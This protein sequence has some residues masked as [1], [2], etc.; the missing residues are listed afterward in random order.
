MA[1][2]IK[3]IGDVS[4]TQRLSRIKDQDLQLISPTPKYKTFGDK[5][6]YIQYTVYDNQRTLLYSSN[7]YL[8]YKLPSNSTLTPEGNYPIIE[9]NPVKDLEDVGYISGEFITQYN[10][11]K[12]IISGPTP[13]LFI[14]EISEDR[15]EIR[16]NSTILSSSQLISW[17]R[18][19]GSSI[20]NNNEQISYILNFPDNLQFLIINFAV[21]FETATP[22]LLLKLYEPLALNIVEKTLGWISEEIVE[23]YLFTVNLNTTVILPPPPRL[24]GPNF[25]ID[26]DTKQNLATKYESYNSLV[27]SLT[28]SSYYRVLNYMNDNSYD[29]NIDYTSF[30]NFIHF[31]SAKKRLEIFY[32][33]IK[34]IEDYNSDIDLLLLSNSILKNE[35]TSSIKL[36]ID[37]IVKNFDGFENYLYFESSSYSWPK[38]TNVKPYKNKFTNKLFHQPITS[39]VWNFTHS[40]NEIPRVISVYSSNS[41]L[42]PTQ[43][44]TIGVNTISITF[45]SSYSGYVILTSPS[46]SLWYN[47]YTS[48]AGLYDE[49]N[50]DHLYNTLPEYIR[51]N[52]DD[53]QS[54][55][56]FIDMIG[57]YF[58]NIWIYITSINELYNADNNLEKG[59]SKDIVYDAL[60][61]LGVK[62]YNSKGDD[63]FDDYIGGINNGSTIFVN[64][65][66]VTSSFL[67]NIP[68]KDQLAELYKRIYH[69]IPLLSKT[70][71]TAAGL[72]NLITTFGI[73][74]S[75]F[76]PKEFG[77]STK[78]NEL[79]G[80]DNDKITIQNNTITGSVLSSF[81][82][83]QNSPSS[84]TEFT[85]T[86]LHFIDLSFSP[87]NELNTRISASVAI[88]YPTFSLDEYIGDPRSM[89]SSSYDS[90]NTFRDTF[91]SASAAVS[92]SAKRLDYKGFIE[93]V[94]YFDN[95]L[96]KML[97][98]FVPARA[99]TLTGVTI[100]SPVLERNKIAVHSPNVTEQNIHEANYNTPVISE[101]KDYYYDKLL[102]N[103]SSFYTG[104]LIGSYANI[105]DTFEL[106]NPNPYLFPPRPID[107]NKHNHSDFN[108]YLNNISSSVLSISRKKLEPLYLSSNSSIFASSS[109]GKISEIVS[110][111]E[112]QDSYEDLLGHQNSRY[113]GTKIYSLKYNE[114]TTSSVNYSG[115]KSFGQKSAI[116][117][118]TIKLGLFTSIE[119]NEFFKTKKNN[120]YLKYLV[121]KEG[122]LTELNK[123]NKHWVEV[124]NIFKSGNNLT[125]AQFD[126]QHD[127]NQ[128]STDGIKP[129]YSSG[130]NYT[131]MLYF[132]GSS[133]TDKLWFA[134]SG[135]DTLK[136]FKAYNI[137]NNFISGS[138]NGTERYPL[139]TSASAQ[140]I[141]NIFDDIEV[142]DKSLYTTGSSTYNYFPSYSAPANGTYAF[143]TSFD[144]NIRF[145]SSNQSCSFKYDVIKGSIDGNGWP[146]GSTLVSSGVKTFTTSYQY[147]VYTRGYNLIPEGAII[148]DRE[149]ANIDSS[150]FPIYVG[151]SLFLAYVNGNRYS[152]GTSDWYS[153]IVDWESGGYTTTSLIF[154]KDPTPLNFSFDDYITPVSN[155][156]SISNQTNGILSLKVNSS[157]DYLQKDDKVY[158]KLSL[159]ST[160]TPNFT[161]SFST[162]GELRNNLTSNS[163][164]DAVFAVGSAADS[165]IS[166][167]TTSSINSGID[168]LVFNAGI[169]AF[170]NYTFVPNTGSQDQSVILYSKYGNVNDTFNPIIGDIVV[171]SWAGQSTE[172][173]ISKVFNSSSYKCLTLDR[174]I[175]NSLIS[176]IR[177]TGDS[178]VAGVDEFILLKKNKDETNLLVTFDKETGNT[179]YGFIIPDNIHPDVLSNI[180]VITKEVKQKLIENSNTGG[181][182]TF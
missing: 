36:K 67:N 52:S 160:S 109:N 65:F 77:G 56:D 42:L 99:N 159:L 161:A 12:S 85:S 94:K 50:S 130:Y 82:S 170:N 153:F 143:N 57:H 126:T 105:N 33:K 21:D 158:F 35:E 60:K 166:N 70:K 13:V 14:D 152:D 147:D 55:F 136:L 98:D 128:K 129:I 84:S 87:Q 104:E 5:D 2:N 90:L 119:K 62:L 146:S 173:N 59:I 131:P 123:Y 112:L 28:G 157:G 156:Q 18:Y 64:D 88:A 80:Y 169:S 78:I 165:F 113:D 30:N 83:L 149:D 178:N 93:L 177:D 101:D 61:S 20:E 17:G 40:L 51:N 41:Q 8:K 174:N 47:S 27:S 23:P 69:N 24:N 114:Y 32:D 31:S 102:G 162:P 66:S 121:D 181:S 111:A 116:D 125:V 48:S 124:Q 108:V 172:F 141:Y 49:D 138:A 54:Y 46:T 175:P 38:A 155:W 122:N 115:D 15:T 96:F 19:L 142:N 134:Y 43:S 137:A 72:Q 58:D 176:K 139:R 11:N 39:S 7:N 100:K 180:D 22:T 71:G 92:G 164:G 37:N 133:S 25:D 117:H 29:L 171:T 1:D 127:G 110:N 76:Q 53:N 6:D 179:S 74:G 68:K 118:N 63:Q 107:V 9:I 91:I 4:N 167:V 154:S 86:D 103:K 168:T 163:S 34:Q 95:S 145:P 26:L 97:K 182:G 132:T 106:S 79:K 89:G 73:T 81:I 148:I 140:I 135:E 144:I 45:P 16:L 151:N 75:I 120:V 150:Y 44:S 10:F 3:I